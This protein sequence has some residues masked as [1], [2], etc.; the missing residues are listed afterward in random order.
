[1]LFLMIWCSELLAESMVVV[2]Q[3]YAARSARLNNPA[4][5]FGQKGVITD[6]LYNL[7]NP[8]Y[9]RVYLCIPCFLGNSVEA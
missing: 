2:I 4:I 3:F 5:L 1:M 9:L 6:G 7:L 8:Q